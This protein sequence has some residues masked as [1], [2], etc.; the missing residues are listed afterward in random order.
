MTRLHPL[1]AL[2]R[3][4][5]YALQGVTIPVVLFLIGSFLFGDAV[6]SAGVLVV[7]PLGGLIGGAY[8]LTQYLRFEYELTDDT[9][10]ITSGV[11]ARRERE[12]PYRRIQT[13]DVTRPLTYRL[14]GVAIVQIETAGGDSTEASLAF[15]STTEA[16][17]IRRLIRT[18][19]ASVTDHSD[20]SQAAVG[21]QEGSRVRGDRDEVGNDSG[22]ASHSEVGGGAHTGGEADGED[23]S[24]LFRLSFGELLVYALSTFRTGAIAVVV[25][26]L[27]L[28][29]DVVPFRV[30]GVVDALGGSTSLSTMTAQ[31]AVVTGSIAAVLLLLGAYVVSAVYGAVTYYGFTLGR[32]GDD[33]IYECG[34]LQRYSGSIP[35]SKVQSVTVTENVPMRRLGYAGLT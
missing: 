22:E 12:I 31:Q 32:R 29:A 23:A 25:F 16:E 34:L 33:L 6:P 8:G 18:R 30:V 15:V 7:A 27:P 11:F 20:G 4:A 19:R 5:R 26:G 17:R 14:F 3:T 10:D 28:V 21:P 13:V 24:V 2:D 1:A 9:L 35:L